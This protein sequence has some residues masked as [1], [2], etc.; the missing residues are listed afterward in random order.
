MLRH[1]AAKRLVGSPAPTVSKVREGQ[2]KPIQVRTPDL[3]G[4]AQFVLFRFTVVSS[5]D[6]GDEGCAKANEAGANHLDR[7]PVSAENG[8]NWTVADRARS[9]IH[10]QCILRA[11]RLA[12]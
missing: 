9:A 5:F 3:H 11:F 8:N 1:P 6:M 10:I 12:V 4:K 2:V 7:D